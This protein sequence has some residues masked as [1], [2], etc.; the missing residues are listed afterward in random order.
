MDET[1]FKQGYTWNEYL[2]HLDET[3]PEDQEASIKEFHEKFEQVL[4]AED[5]IAVIANIQSKV[6]VVALAEYWCPDV[7]AH[8]PVMARLAELN[9]NIELR[10]FPRDANLE[11]MQQYLFRGK[12]MSIPAFG[13]F[14]EDFKEFGKWK[15]GRP[16]ICWDWI[17]ELGKDGARPK[18]K[19]F[20]AE[21]R[22]QETLKEFI[23]IIQAQSRG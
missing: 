15:G 20:Y 10:I 9:A 12:S 11:L 6:N 14:D 3:V 13:F 1:H 23:A 21:N 7:R 8:L 17:D 5:A 2:N 19:D 18:I 4:I 16:K 22:G